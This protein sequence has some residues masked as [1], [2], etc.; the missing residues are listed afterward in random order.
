VGIEVRE[1]SDED[2]LRMAARTDL[3]SF[4][5]AFE[6]ARFEKALPTRRAA[7]S[8]LAHDDD[9]PVGAC[10]TH[11]FSMTLP[12]GATV[13]VSGVADVGVLPSHRRRGV[14]SAMMERMLADGVAAG[15]VAAGLHASESTIYGRFGFGAATRHRKVSIATSRAAMRSDVLVSPGVVEVLHPDGRG[16][17]LR[18]VHEEAMG[19]RPGEVGR[20][21]PQW[22]VRIAGDASDESRM[23][24]MVHRRPSGEPDA[25]A[26]YRIDSDW[27]P[28]GPEHLLEVQ[29]LV[30]VDEPA[31][32][33]MWQAVLG[34][35]LVATVVAWVPS[36][37]ILFDA[38]E[39]RW[40]PHS[41]GEHDGLWLRLLDVPSVLGSRRY[42][43]P[44]TV[45]FD[46]VDDRAPE[47][48]ATA[49]TWA[50]EVGDDG[51]A[52]VE[53]C[54]GSADL[55]LGVAELASVVLGGGSLCRLGAVGRVTAVT[56]GALE[57]ADAMLGWWPSPW[58]TEFF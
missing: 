44:G 55:R 52:G 6:Q 24:C 37:S 58:I 42:R 54:S 51:A 30:A 22:E 23:L 14:L 49:G 45:V 40:A 8:Y 31:E 15:R 36:D 10:M 35:D 4:G 18:R 43:I 16:D 20:L 41:T 48:A 21:V 2:D 46:V 50:V 1:I 25:Y 47:G 39:D 13:P 34:L 56:P 5:L 32:L 28:A 53:R 17:V 38:L 27:A 7:T 11:A 29:E 12:G 9:T 3:A 26:L 19:R 33:A 57:R